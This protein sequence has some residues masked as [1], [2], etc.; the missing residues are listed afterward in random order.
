MLSILPDT[1]VQ[2]VLTIAY[3]GCHFLASVLTKAFAALPGRCQLPHTQREVNFMH[4]GHEDLNSIN[5]NCIRDD[6]LCM[7]HKSIDGFGYLCQS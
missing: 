6:A 2:P 5:W 3:D 1:P 7:K 4:V